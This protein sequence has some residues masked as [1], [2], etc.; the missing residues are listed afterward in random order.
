MSDVLS[1]I[2]SSR[3]SEMKVGLLVVAFLLSV[4]YAFVFRAGW[5]FVVVTVVLVG[6]L[7]V[8]VP[9]FVRLVR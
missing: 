1:A 7:S 6:V 3:T 9:Y 4:V 2:G 8:L 5:L